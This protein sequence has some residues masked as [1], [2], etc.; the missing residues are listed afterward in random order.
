MAGFQLLQLHLL[1]VLQWLTN[2]PV[3]DACTD[4]AVRDTV[5]AAF[6][7]LTGWHTSRRSP[8][9]CLTEHVNIYSAWPDSRAKRE[10]LQ[11]QPG[12]WCGAVP[13]CCCNS[14]SLAAP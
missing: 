9:N 8:L 4:E 6:V 5:G 11:E 13:A 1:T 2:C 3:W 10:T 7:E 14:A 12:C